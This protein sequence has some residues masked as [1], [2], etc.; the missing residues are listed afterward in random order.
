MRRTASRAAVVLLLL[1][2]GRSAFAGGSLFS[3]VSVEPAAFSP[4]RGEAVRL[5]YKLETRDEISI[6]VYDP[7]GGLVR[8]LADAVRQ[9]AGIHEL[10]WDGRDVDGR[11]VPDEAYTFVLRSG[12]GAVYDPATVSGGVVG[13][14]TE[15]HFDRDGTVTYRLPAPARVLIRLGIHNGPMLKTLVDWK[16]RVAGT[17]TEY[18][19]GRDENGLMDLRGAK[20]FSA[21]I[22]Y[23]T[24]PE[25]S[26]IAYGNGGSSYRDYKLGPAA[27]RPQ[28][29]ARPRHPD[30]RAR[31]RPEL[32]VPPAWARAPRVALQFPGIESPAGKGPLQV[33]EAVEVRIDVDPADRARLQDDQFEVI[34]FV[35]DVFF[36]EA[37]RGY[38]PLNWHWELQQLPPGPH[39]LTVNV[40]SFR[41][42][43]GVASRRVNVVRSP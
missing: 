26:V 31:L 38:L 4:A 24:L 34:L 1:A 37:E 7:D 17:I 21:L 8:T 15:A 5:Q 22:T 19:D 25:A 6:R 27:G 18:W 32:L 41:G 43:V 40:S 14:L 39:V 9:Q 10:R 35:D 16:P 29:P 42:Q 2:A 28:K 33:G 30:P 23:V 11:T 36:A 20:G 12:S 3:E 13:D